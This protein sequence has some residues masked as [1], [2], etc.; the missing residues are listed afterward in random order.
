[1]GDCQ[2]T[3]ERASASDIARLFGEEIPEVE[4]TCLDFSLEQQGDITCLIVTS[5]GKRYRFFGSEV[6]NNGGQED[7]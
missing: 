1:M 5:G 3:H 7:T 4:S 2:C 6:P